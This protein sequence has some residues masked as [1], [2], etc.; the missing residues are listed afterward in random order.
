MARDQNNDVLITAFHSTNTC[1][2]NINYLISN[3]ETR[4]KNLDT[5]S[6]VKNIRYSYV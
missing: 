1:T 2:H 3:L 6:Y 5:A 4:I